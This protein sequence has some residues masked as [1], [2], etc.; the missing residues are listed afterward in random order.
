MVINIITQNAEVMLECDD[1]GFQTKMH[2]YIEDGDLVQCEGC[3]KRYV[4][5]IEE[6]TG[7]WRDNS[8]EKIA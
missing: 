2:T 4:V 8:V 1:C 7:E 6:Y 3:Q 5:R